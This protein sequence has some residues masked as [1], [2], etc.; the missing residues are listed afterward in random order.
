M[1][2]DGKAFRKNSD[3]KNDVLTILIGEFYRVVS[4]VFLDNFKCFDLI[5]ALKMSEE[6]F[7]VFTYSHLSF[8]VGI[9]DTALF[10]NIGE[11][12]DGVEFVKFNFLN[13][14]HNIIL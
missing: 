6:F 12:E 14:S 13:A 5:F 7:N 8:I 2:A 1:G 9:F 3:K 10:E 4:V 11:G